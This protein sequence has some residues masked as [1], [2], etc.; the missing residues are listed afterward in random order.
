MSSVIIPVITGPTASGKSELVYDYA[1]SRGDIEVVSADAFQV[2]K[3]LDI[4]TA[5]PDMD[6]RREIPH[7]LIDIVETDGSFNVGDFVGKAEKVIE[8]ILNRGRQPIVV[9]G[10]GLYIR[11]LRDGIFS[12]PDIDA[13]LRD[14]LR[15][16]IQRE[17]SAALYEELAKAD[18]DVAAKIHPNDHVRIIRGLEVWL[19]S[20]V[21]ISSAREL[22]RTLPAYSYDIMVIDKDRETLYNDINLRVRHMLSHGWP[23]EVKSLLDMGYNENLP[24]FRAIGYADLAKVF[25]YGNKIAD[26]EEK[27][28]QRT[29]N[30]AKRQLTWF[31]GM[32]G[33][34]HMSADDIIH[35]LKGL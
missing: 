2:Y 25:L 21:T 1:R 29:R 26:A 22:K 9:G 6:I 35:K 19:S 30:F 20:G 27:I 14:E 4:G 17:G 33:V 28:A 16:R 24:A 10:T 13:E 12:A 5:K 34:Y 3:G 18:P 7:H 31:R 8:E 32:G 23:E 15:A 11:T